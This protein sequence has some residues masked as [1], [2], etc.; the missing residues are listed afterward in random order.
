MYERSYMHR[1]TLNFVAVTKYV[2]QIIIRTALLCPLTFGTSRNDFIITTSQDG[3]LKF[4][5]KTSNGIEF[6][7]HYRSHLSN[8]NGINVSA[9]GELLATISEDKSMKVYDITQFGK[10][11]S[12]ME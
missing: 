9:D 6:V 11:I 7:K 3:H 2:H 1:D 5:K 4:W 8:I 10:T 12:S